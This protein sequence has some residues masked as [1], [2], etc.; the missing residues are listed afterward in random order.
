MHPALKRLIEANAELTKAQQALESAQDQRRACALQLSEIEDE[1]E[2]WQAALFAYAKF[3]KGLSLQLAEAATGLPGRRAQSTFLVRAGRK[4]HQPK[5]NGGGSVQPAEPMTEWP[6][7]DALERELIRS[8][9]AHGQAY[10]ID[11]GLGWGNVR[12]ALEPEE[13]EE[14]LV[15]PTGA[16]ARQ[17]GLSREDFVEWLSSEGS[18][19]CEGVT[20]SGARC[21]AGVV[22]V[23]SQLPVKAWKEA[24]ARGGYCG[25]HGG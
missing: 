11:R 20:L 22:G 24:K 8:H 1:A 19:R 3:G 17:A 6:A 23:S 2:R 9:I 16:M 5:G 12:I 7:P 21:K 14:Y 10:W 18:I 15:D 13:A 25:R 4:E